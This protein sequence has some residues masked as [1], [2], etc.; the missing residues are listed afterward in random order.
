MVRF[1]YIRG[2]S[3]IFVQE[4]LNVLGMFAPNPVSTVFLP[5]PAMWPQ[6]S[7]GSRKQELFYYEYFVLL[8]VRVLYILV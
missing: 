1:M 7:S 4:M 2:H 8:F 5:V 6:T 3:D